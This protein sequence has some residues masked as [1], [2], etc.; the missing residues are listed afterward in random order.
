MAPT[1]QLSWC[2][3]GLNSLSQVGACGVFVESMGQGSAAGLGCYNSVLKCKQY[4]DTGQQWTAELG[5]VALT[6]APLCWFCIS[7]FGHLQA[8]SGMG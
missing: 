4:E 8:F 3:G 1:R 2:L 6:G 7:H 5:H